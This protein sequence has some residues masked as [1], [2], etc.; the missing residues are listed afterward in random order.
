MK[1]GPQQQAQ[2]FSELR[3]SLKEADALLTT[4]AGL[5][6]GGASA[7]AAAALVTKARAGK[8]N[9]QVVQK[10]AARLRPAA[11]AACVRVARQQRRPAHS[12]CT[13][14]CFDCQNKLPRR[15]VSLSLWPAHQHA[16]GLPAQRG[17][18]GQGGAKLRF[19]VP[20]D[21]L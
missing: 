3:R 8:E 11:L 1:R 5:N 10:H 19:C 20:C 9:G 4:A 15:P 21:A 2:L 14:A 17:V 6:T 16:R 18:D 13:Q 7:A 12:Y